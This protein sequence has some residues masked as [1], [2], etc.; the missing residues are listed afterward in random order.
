MSQ[1]TSLEWEGVYTNVRTA[2]KITPPILLCLPTT[3]E[4]D[5]GGMAVGLEPSH[6]YFITIFC[7]VT[8]GSRG[9]V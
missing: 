2:L 7:C 9:E 1:Y 6:Q 3:P 8:D 5:V 4:A